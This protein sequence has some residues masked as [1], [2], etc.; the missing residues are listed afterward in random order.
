MISVSLA[1]SDASVQVT[2]LSFCVQV[3]LPLR[4]ST[5]VK[6]GGMVI[7]ATRLLAASGPRFVYVA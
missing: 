3:K 6:P 1:P 5:P 2:T 7:V 4:V